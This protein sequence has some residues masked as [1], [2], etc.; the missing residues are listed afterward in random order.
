MSTRRQFLLSTAAATLAVAGCRRAEHPPPAVGGFVGPDVA[1]GH[2]LRDA[3]WD[4]KS[5]TAPEPAVTRRVRTLIAGGGVAGL[6]AARALRLRGHDDFALLELEDQPG[7]NARA[8]EL[9]GIPCPLGAHYLPVPGDHAPHVQHLLE[10]LGVRQR[11]AGRWGYDER[12]LCH[13]PQE[14]LYLNGHWQPGLL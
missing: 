12:H 9:G 10:E 4:S 8:G 13:S 6:A 11:V 1:R 14:R 5:G 7:G 3:A 2:S